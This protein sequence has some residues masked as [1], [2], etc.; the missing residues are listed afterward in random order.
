MGMDGER[1][2]Q[3][4]GDIWGSSHTLTLSETGNFHIIL[5]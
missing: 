3:I 4:F 1:Y 5:S 2:A